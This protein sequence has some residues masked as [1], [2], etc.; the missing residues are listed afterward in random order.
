MQPQKPQAPENTR[1]LREK[2]L[3]D[4]KTLEL[5]GKLGLSQEEYL[6]R[7]VR[8]FLHPPTEP[9]LSVV[10]APAPQ[11]VERKGSPDPRPTAERPEVRSAS[12]RKVG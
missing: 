6:D 11:D 8:F 3:V 9:L 7:V 5:A 2:V 1:T 12:R 4:G 10:E